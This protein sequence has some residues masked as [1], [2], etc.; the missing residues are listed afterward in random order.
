MNNK[1]LET[2]VKLKYELIT[3]HDWETVYVWDLIDAKYPNGICTKIKER[4]DRYVDT[5]HIKRTDNHFE[6]FNCYL[7]EE[8]C[9]Y[10]NNQLI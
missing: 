9:I 8:L 6:L 1:E 2:L 4:W 3:I 10:E 5:V 7:I